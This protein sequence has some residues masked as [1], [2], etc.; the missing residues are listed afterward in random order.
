MFG[1]MGARGILA[2]AGGAA[3]A[4]EL[5]PDPGIDSPVAWDLNSPAAASIS[6]GSM[7]STT[8]DS[9]T[10][11]Q[12]MLLAPTVAGEQYRLTVDE[13]SANGAIY[14]IRMRTSGGAEQLVANAFDSGITGREFLFTAAAEQDRLRIAFH[15]TNIQL[16]R[17]SLVP[18]T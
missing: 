12:T 8:G 18:V 10:P 13:V 14:R 15:D 5:L 1:L 2:D 16:T 4:S 9:A 6:G 17:I 3:P 11:V 7:T